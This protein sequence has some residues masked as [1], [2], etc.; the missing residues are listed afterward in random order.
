MSGVKE[1]RVPSYDIQQVHSLRDTDNSA[2]R[3]SFGQA[4]LLDLTMTNNL[5]G[6]DNR[7]A[8]P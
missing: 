3:D 4:F 5:R 6:I 1:H 7:I 8:R 2:C